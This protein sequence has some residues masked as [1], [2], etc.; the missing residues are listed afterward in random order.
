MEEKVFKVFT[1]PTSDLSKAKEYT[2]TWNQGLKKNIYDYDVEMPDMPPEEDIINFG[3]PIE[4]QVFRKTQ[5]PKDLR[6]WPKEKKEEFIRVEHHRR[7]H[8]LWFF[9]KGEP[10]YIPGTMYF[11][12]NYWVLETGKPPVFRMSDL[13]FFLIWM[14]VVRTPTIFGLIVF[15]C[16][17]I[18]DTEKGL[19]IIYEYASRV[20]NTLN[21]MQDGRTIDDIFKTYQRLTFAHEKMIWFMKPINRGTTNPKAALEFKIPERKTSAK[22]YVTQNGDLFLDDSEFEFDAIG[23]TITY[24]PSKP[25]SGDGKRHGRYYFDEFGKKKML[26]ALDAWKFV[27]KSMVD[28]IYKVLAGKALFTSTIEE[29]KDG[30]SLKISKKLWKNSD[31]AVLNRAGQTS[32]GLIRIVRGTLEKGDLDRWGYVDKEARRLEI[33]EERRYLI[34]TKDWSGL[35]THQRQECIDISDVFTN[36][37]EGSNFN[38]ENLTQRQ[39][40]LDFEINPKK[41]S[42]GNFEWMDGKKPVLGN[43]NGVNKQCKVIWVPSSNGRFYVSGHPKDWNMRDNAMQPQVEVPSPYN[44]HAFCAGIDPVSQKDVLDKDEMSLSGLVIKRKYDPRID[45]G[46]FD[47]KGKPIDGGENFTTNRYVCAYLYRHLEPTDNYDDWLK[48]L[49]YFGSDFL[50]EKNHGAGF[51]QY[52]EARGFDLYYMDNATGIR[53]HKGQQEQWG[54]SANDKTIEYYFS[55]L[56]TISNEWHNTI[57]IPVIC[58]QLKSMT[59]E[60]RGKRDLGVA[61]GYCEMAAQ[62]EIESPESDDDKENN[63]YNMY[64]DEHIV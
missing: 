49:V 43:P 38:I 22:S 39:H 1:S 36:V 48:A 10:V 42:T 32:T 34:E 59:V 44:I 5:I 19:C 18:G 15:K 53:N 17:R 29:M 21:A 12:M 58:D 61:A 54:I 52:L 35:I 2:R 45:Q 14:H 62:K 46:K 60:N 6:A 56:T 47:E 26:S 31:P 20:K 24:Y 50:I 27:K 4:E 57:D 25:E 23:S 33:E 9:I 28:D 51:Q 7:K 30:E 37:S 40:R 8:G 64:F 16:R 11:F 41:W 13:D 63:E 55:L 3:L